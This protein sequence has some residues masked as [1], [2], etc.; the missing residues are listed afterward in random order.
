MR[1]TV[2]LSLDSY[3]NVPEVLW[4]TYRTILDVRAVSRRHA[5]D[6][7]LSK[8]PETFRTVY[9]RAAFPNVWTLSPSAEIISEG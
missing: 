5:L 7:A 9:Y 4:D 3:R 2:R 1:Y 6:K 8:A